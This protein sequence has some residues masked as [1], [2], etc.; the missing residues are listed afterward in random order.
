[1]IHPPGA[2]QPQWQSPDGLMEAGTTRV[3]AWEVGYINLGPRL[4]MGEDLQ[5]MIQFLQV[6]PVDKPLLLLSN[7]PGFALSPVA[8]AE[9]LVFTAGAYRALLQ[10]RKAAGGLIFSYLEDIA[11]GGVYLMHGLVAQCRAAA[12]GTQ[13]FDTVPSRPAVPLSQALDRGLLDEILP[14]GT[15][16]P[17]LTT[18]L[19]KHNTKAEP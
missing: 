5:G 15:L 9:G 12:E 19:S 17:W 11:V 13:F 1:M 8:E 3:N 10:E 4:L 18:L 6:I 2:A 14:E 7:C 16:E